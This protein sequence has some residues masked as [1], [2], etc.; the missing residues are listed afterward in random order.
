MVSGAILVALNLLACLGLVLFLL[1]QHPQT[2]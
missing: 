1:A 2:Y